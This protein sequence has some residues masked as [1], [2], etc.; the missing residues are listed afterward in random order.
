VA[1][2]ARDA[3]RTLVCVAGAL[4]VFRAFAVT[5]KQKG[6]LIIG[7]AFGNVTYLGMPLLQ[8]LFPEQLLLV[9][10]IA[11]LCEITVTSSDLITGFL[12]ATLYQDEGKPS[13][14]AAFGQI[15][16]FPL[17]LSAMVAIIIRVVGIP[18]P[19]F[20]LSALHLLGQCTSG[21]MLLILGMALKP[22][23]LKRSLHDFRQWW[24]LLIIKLGLSPLVVGFAGAKIG[25]AYLNLHAVTIEAAM[26]P[27]LFTFIVADRFGF[28]VEAL[29]SAV[30]FMTVVSLVTVPII[31]RILTKSGIV[32]QHPL[33]CARMLL[34]SLRIEFG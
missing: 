17:I 14:K 26:P 5:P 11:I 23:V 6:S 2:S 4:L 3:D 10:E 21:L 7:S 12:L 13:I 25:L 34:V 24:P 22:S 33:P 28:D 8:R 30:A 16:R 1:G 27:Q 29:A 9:T 32:H 15:A 20:L 19:E 18:L 31:N